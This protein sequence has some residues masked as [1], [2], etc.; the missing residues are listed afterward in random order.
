MKG[1]LSF[2]EEKEKN[3]KETAVEVTYDRGFCCPRCLGVGI[4]E[5]CKR[6]KYCPGCGQ[7]LKFV[8]KNRRKSADGF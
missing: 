2:F 8:K 4:G 5:A 7:K 6:Y 1:Q 3:D